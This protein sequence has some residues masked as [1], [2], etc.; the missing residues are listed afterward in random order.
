MAGQGTSSQTHDYQ[1]LDR[2]LARY[3][4]TLVYYRLRQ[5][6]QDGTVNYSPVRS[7]AVPVVAGLALFP[8][9]TRATATLTGVEPGTQVQVYDALGRL[10][11][12]A[13]AD[14]AGTA[15]LRLP[16]GL[17][18]GV[19]LVRVGSKALRLSVAD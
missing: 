10:V 14:A 16:P 4:A 7:V 3:A 19:Y 2:S 13:T 9:P 12:A 11:L 8:N 6:D 5:V 1:W 18:Q 15:A 17:A